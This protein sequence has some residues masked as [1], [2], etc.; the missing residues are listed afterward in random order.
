MERNEIYQLFFSITSETEIPLSLKDQ[1]RIC[2]RNTITTYTEPGLQFE[3][4][5]NTLC[6][7]KTLKSFLMFEELE[8]FVSVRDEVPE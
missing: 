3:K 8:Q 7:P 2:I 4:C 6:M 5:I 1:C